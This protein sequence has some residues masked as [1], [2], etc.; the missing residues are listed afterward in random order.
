MRKIDA[1]ALVEDLQE[2]LYEED[3]LESSRNK[4]KDRGYN[5]GVKLAIRRIKYHAPTIK[6]EA[7][8]S[9]EWVKDD[10]GNT[11]CSKCHK[12]LPYFHCY[13]EGSG[14]EWDEEIEETPYCMYCGVKMNE[15]SNS[16]N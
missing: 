3:E 4:D 16:L 10:L 6:D 9:A 2:Y 5:N 14:D 15:E 7:S 11:Y 1:D 8:E 13:D 12:R